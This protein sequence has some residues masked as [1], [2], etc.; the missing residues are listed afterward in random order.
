MLL[1][2]LGIHCKSVGGGGSIDRTTGYLYKISSVKAQQI[3]ANKRL[4]LS[5]KHQFDVSET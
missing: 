4:F 1:L 3:I 5:F 2:G